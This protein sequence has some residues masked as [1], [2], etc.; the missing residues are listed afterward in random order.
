LT[1]LTLTPD[2]RGLLYEEGDPHSGNPHISLLPL[3]ASADPHAILQTPFTTAQGQISPDGRYLAYASNETGR[4]EVYVRRFPAGDERWQISTSSGLE[5]QW[6]RDGHELLFLAG[7]RTLMSIPVEAG[8]TFS[9]GQ[10]R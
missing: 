9:I 6:R 2:G 1:P 8:K 7:D 5:P 10:A 4:F 3:A